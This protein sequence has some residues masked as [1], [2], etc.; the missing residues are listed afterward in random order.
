MIMKIHLQNK[1]GFTLIEMLIATSIFAVVILATS[2]IFGSSSRLQVSTKSAIANKQYA[3]Q[4]TDRIFNDLK[5]CNGWGKVFAKKD[6]HAEGHYKIKGFGFFHYGIGNIDIFPYI[7]DTESSDADLIIGFDSSKVYYYYFNS[8][9]QVQI[10]S[11]NYNFPSEITGSQIKAALEGLS[12]TTLTPSGSKI[13]SFKITGRNYMSSGKEDPKVEDLTDTSGRY[14]PFMTLDLT[15]VEIDRF[16]NP[17][18]NKFQVRT[19]I[20]SRN[21]LEEPN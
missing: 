20:S 17:L 8:D 10:A 5:S 13:D 12:S 3:T 2:T 1:S 15:F 21:Y 4:I 7:K 18:N 6:S 9:H 14:Q 16:G 11:E 19:S